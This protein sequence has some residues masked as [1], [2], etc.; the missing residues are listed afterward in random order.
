[1]NYTKKYE[2]L[3]ELNSAHNYGQR[4]KTDIKQCSAM[5][6]NHMQCWRAS[7]ILITK[8][9]TTKIEGDAAAEPILSTDTVQMCNRHAQ[10]DLDEYN[11]AVNDDA[12]ANA[13]AAQP[14][15]QAADV[16][17]PTVAAT[18]PV[19]IAAAAPTP[20]K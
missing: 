8:T 9:T 6:P 10:A 19:K 1:M 2:S 16:A 18:S 15:V 5:L 14:V 13:V 4:T 12:N 11:K 7:D 17:K 20:T 3:T